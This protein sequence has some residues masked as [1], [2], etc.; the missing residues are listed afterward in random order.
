MCILIAS[1][2]AVKLAEEKSKNPLFDSNDDGSFRKAIRELSIYDLK[3]QYL[4]SRG[5]RT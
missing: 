1:R 3:V 4:E 5:F 2:V